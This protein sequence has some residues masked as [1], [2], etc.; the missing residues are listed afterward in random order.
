ML[1]VVSHH[2]STTR[3]FYTYSSI[4]EKGILLIHAFPR[5]PKSAAFPAQIKIPFFYYLQVAITKSGI[6]FLV[7]W[8]YFILPPLFELIALF[9]IP[10]TVSCLVVQDP[11]TPLL[12]WYA[13][14]KGIK[15]VLSQ[16]TPC[17]K[18]ENRLTREAISDSQLIAGVQSKPNAADEGRSPLALVRGDQFYA[19]RA[20][21][22]LCISS[23]AATTY[24][25]LAKSKVQSYIPISMVNHSRNFG[26]RHHQK[27]SPSPAD[28][29]LKVLLAGHWTARK[30]FYLAL[31]A[32]QQHLD[33]R[34]CHLI[35]MGLC[36]DQFVHDQAKSS[37]GSFVLLGHRPHSE[38]LDLMRSCD[39]LLHPAY[40]EGA[41]YVILEA[42]HAGMA[43]ISSKNCIGPDVIEDGQTGLLLPDL[44]LQSIASSVQS[45]MD[46]RC[47]LS[48][49]QSAARQEASHHLT[50]V[51]AAESLDRALVG[52]SL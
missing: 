33:S 14:L 17:K 22:I 20:D 27:N 24:Q 23:F 10:R 46:D 25:G 39:I 2:A 1:V 48:L 11:V 28:A 41:A 12:Y 52:L 35:H 31:S 49:I 38:A 50:P 3:H 19:K 30:G 15:L 45:L 37:G 40:S 42:M 9:F 47:K 51:A 34:Y 6:N 21:G 13:K 8:S 29:P 16:A 44:S 43:V 18:V 4:C 26:E 5:L 36:S 7:E 32:F